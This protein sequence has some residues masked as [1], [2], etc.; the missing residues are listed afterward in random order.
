MPQPIFISTIKKFPVR[1][2]V[3]KAIFRKY[4]KDPEGRWQS[5][6]S[7]ECYKLLAIGI[8]NNYRKK[9]VQITIKEYIK[10]IG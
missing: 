10:Y 9:L 8:K 4:S 7:L 1:I 5:S 2:S 3:G 6:G